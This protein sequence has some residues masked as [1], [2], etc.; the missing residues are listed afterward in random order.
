MTIS[1]NTKD[2]INAVLEF[3]Y[4]N[5]R[6]IF[7]EHEFVNDIIA[8][9]LVH[10]DHGPEVEELLETWFKDQEYGFY[11]VTP[12]KAA[13]MP[14]LYAT[15]FVGGPEGSRMF[16]PAPPHITRRSVEIYH[17][18][19]ELDIDQINRIPGDT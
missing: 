9:C 5:K 14:P 4:L 18:R 6:R 12:K 7:L 17:K 16:F 10:M 19:K 8:R 11:P 2:V 1:N 15:A 3:Q 13:S